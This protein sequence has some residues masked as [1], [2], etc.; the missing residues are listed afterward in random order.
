MLLNDNDLSGDVSF[1]CTTSS[2][3]TGIPD[4]APQQ[5]KLDILM[6]DCG[7]GGSI[8]CT[9]CHTCCPSGESC[10]NATE[11]LG[12]Q[13]GIWEFGYQRIKW[14]FDGDAKF[15]WLPVYIQP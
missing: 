15:S 5:H 14:S 9:C 6:A 8:N 13:A 4:D 2:D 12:N 3:T 7:D 1:L 11:W 10:N